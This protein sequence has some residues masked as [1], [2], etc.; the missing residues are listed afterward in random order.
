MKV[1]SY[2]H[3]LFTLRMLGSFTATPRVRFHDFVLR[4]RDT[5][6]YTLFN[7]CMGL[8]SKSRDN[9]V[10]IATGYGL[11]GRGVGVRVPVGHEFSLF[12]VVQTGCGVHLTSP[13]G[14]G[15]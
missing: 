8:Y 1:A 6:T 10:G 2:L 11:D 7:E 14:K 3:V 15:G 4:H 12:H 5:F 13:V 9:A